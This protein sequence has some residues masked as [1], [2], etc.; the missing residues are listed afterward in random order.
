MSCCALF[1]GIVPVSILL[2]DTAC[3]GPIFGRS[4]KEAASKKKKN[5]RKSFTSSHSFF[6]PLG[7]HICL[8]NRF[9][10]HVITYG[11]PSSFSLSQG[12]IPVYSWSPSFRNSFV[13]ILLSPLQIN[14]TFVE[15]SVLKSFLN[16]LVRGVFSQEDTLTGTPFAG[17]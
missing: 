5:H 7:E 10:Y 17:L 12:I 13:H 9:I 2:A 3:R 16:T 11:S 8:S 1:E 14:V 15:W 6:W 4:G